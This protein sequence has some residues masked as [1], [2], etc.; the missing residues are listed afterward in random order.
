MRDVPF[1]THGFCFFVGGRLREDGLVGDECDPDVALEG[2][3]GGVSVV[4]MVDSSF[5]QY[6]LSP[7]GLLISNDSDY[8]MQ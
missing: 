6:F 4:T 8:S 3:E 5:L 2:E 1:S 7:T